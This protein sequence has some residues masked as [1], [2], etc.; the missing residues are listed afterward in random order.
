MGKLIKIFFRTLS[1][2]LIAVD[3]F[4]DPGLDV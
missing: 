4:L 3:A 2:P 1:M